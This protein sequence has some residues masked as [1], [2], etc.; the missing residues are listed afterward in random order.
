[1]V[2]KPKI[3]N[4]VVRTDSF[5]DNIF[6]HAGMG[7]QRKKRGGSGFDAIYFVTNGN[8]VEIE[9][10]LPD[11]AYSELIVSELSSTISTC[12]Y[13]LRLGKYLRSPVQITTRI[14]GQKQKVSVRDWLDKSVNRGDGS[15]LFGPLLEHG[16][17]YSE[18]QGDHLEP[19]PAIGVAARLIVQDI[20]ENGGLFSDEWYF[21]K[22][23]Q[24]YF[25]P[26]YMREDQIHLIGVLWEQLA[27][28]QANEESVL[29]GRSAVEADRLRGE[30]GKSDIRRLERISSLITHMEKLTS[31]NP[32]LVRMGPSAVGEI[33]M[34]DAMADNPS[35]WSQGA[36]QLDSYLT[37]LASDPKF[38][39]RY[40]N[41]FH[42]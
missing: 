39:Y 18:E 26:K 20:C 5:D 28:K 31:N 35:L 2:K 3:E 22:I 4:E 6:G 25:C 15:S 37:V 9:A 7:H 32:D 41:L 27:Q 36:G 24:E 12:V 21:A 14:C 16:E 23:L 8:A 11:G 10:D 40:D 13:F 33:A 34:N 19:I 30:K 38:K 1:M 42:S 29:R 17:E